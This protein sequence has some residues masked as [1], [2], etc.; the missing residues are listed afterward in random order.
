M[1]P[2][3]TPFERRRRK[4]PNSSDMGGRSLHVLDAGPRLD[5]RLPSILV[6]DDGGQLH[7]GA[8]AVEGVDYRGV[9][10]RHEAA[11]HL[12][13]ARHLRVVGL[14]ILGEEEEAADLRA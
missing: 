12:A 13:G 14:E 5:R 3:S 7:L 9:L 4:K 6:G 10:L 2:I 11:A 8:A 1:R